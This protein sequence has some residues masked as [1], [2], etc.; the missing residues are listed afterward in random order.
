[1]NKARRRAIVKIIQMLHKIK[2]NLCREFSELSLSQ[3]E[4]IID[5]IQCILDEEECVRDNIPENLQNGCRYEES[6]NACDIMGDIISD[7]DDIDEDCSQ[8]EVLSYISN[9][10]NMLSYI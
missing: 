4:E 7:F 2:S 5:E 1:M 8:E 10:I 9:A 6:E 3:L